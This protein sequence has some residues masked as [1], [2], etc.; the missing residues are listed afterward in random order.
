MCT[1][2]GA[3][4]AL[5]THCA[6]SLCASLHV[7]WTCCPP[8]CDHLQLPS[9][10]CA[11]K[12]LKLCAQ[13]RLILGGT[14]W[15]AATMLFMHV[16]CKCHHFISWLQSSSRWLSNFKTASCS[17]LLEGG[18]RNCFVFRA[19]R[20]Q[21]CFNNGR[22]NSNDDDW[23]DDDDDNTDLKI[24]SGLMEASDPIQ[25]CHWVAETYLIPTWSLLSLLTFKQL[26]VSSLRTI[27]DK[28]IGPIMTKT[29]ICILDF[30]LSS[31]ICHLWHQSD[32][33]NSCNSCI[34]RSCFVC[35]V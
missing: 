19:N 5:C 33:A 16:A 20:F 7:H 12:S 8:V 2:H 26:K 28:F 22:Q 34:F 18:R 24:K 4:S 32:S 27:L 11:D 23:N 1:V 21:C 25:I 6:P 3:T 13:W 35:T 14:L 30:S 15:R 29:L 9:T 31:V 10:C 17:R